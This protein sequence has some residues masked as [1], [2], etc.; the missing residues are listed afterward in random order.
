MQNLDNIL[1]IRKNTQVKLMVNIFGYLPM[2]VSKRHIV[3]NYLIERL[4]R[5]MNHI[6]EIHLLVNNNN[7]KSRFL[8]I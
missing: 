8:G 3:K 6:K 5:T 2:F 1:E 4:S 7:N